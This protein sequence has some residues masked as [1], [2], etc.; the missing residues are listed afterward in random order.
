EDLI[1]LGRDEVR[2]ILLQ[3]AMS[4]Y[5][6]REQELGSE[7]MRELERVILLRTVDRHWMFFI[8]EMH[9]LRQNINLRAY[10]Q[11]DPL[12]AYKRESYDMFEGMIN[13]IQ[14]EVVRAIYQVR[15]V[16]R[17][18][19]QA[20]AGPA[21]GVRPRVASLG[22]GSGAAPASQSP[23]PKSQPVTAE[24]IGRNDPC[25]CGSGKKYKKCCGQ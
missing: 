23:S 7:T 1:D 11:Q 2:Q 22:S 3:E 21:V 14:D 10:G 20:V 9:E 24:K 18:Q 16:A 8:D 6:Q 13:T 19:R 17:P 15:V 12:V 25:P 5:D 4:H